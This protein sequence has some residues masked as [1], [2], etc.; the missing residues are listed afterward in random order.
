MMKLSDSSK[1][2]LILLGFSLVIFNSVSPLKANSTGLVPLTELGSDMY[3]GYEGGLYP[4]G[5][6][7]IPV[8]HLALG[9]M[10]A[11]EVIPRDANGNPDPNG[12]IVMI[13][14]GMSNTCHEFG[15]FERVADTDTYRN[16]RLVIINGAQGGQAAE[17][18]DD[19]NAP[20]W[21]LITERLAGNNLTVQQVQVAW[22][23]QANR[24]PDNNFP[25]HA[26]G[27][28][29]N[30]R[31]IVSIMHNRYSNLKLFYI[32][33]R[34]YA[35]YATGNLNP[36]PQSYESGF[37]VKWLIGDQINGDADLNNDPDQSPVMAPWLGWGPYLWADGLIPRADGLIWER[38]DFEGD[39]THPSAG[40]EQK[41]ADL[42][43]G[44]FGTVATTQWYKARAGT[45]LVH[46]DTEADAH[47][48]IAEPGV[49]FG[50][51][52]R[53]QITGGETKIYLRFDLSG[54]RVPVIRSKLSM[55]T[56]QG[57][58][59]AQL[60]TVEDSSWQEGTITF[61]NAPTPANDSFITMGN[62]SRDGSVSGDVTEQVNADADGIV[63]FAVVAGGG[64]G[65]CHS[66]EGGQPPRL[67][68]TLAT[69]GGDITGN[70]IT[71]FE[72]LG[73]L[74]GHWLW[75]GAA[76]GVG[77][78]VIQD[79]IVNF[80]DYSKLTGNWMKIN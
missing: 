14:I 44:F 21:R 63:T 54:I 67:I 22:M 68:L 25:I 11:D 48:W 26:Q 33:S 30:L 20:Y 13:S 70:G 35:G 76:G 52:S 61:Y 5:S 65:S 23:K 47:V 7:D 73:R 15:V 9:Q 75:I 1:T 72:D 60:F 2:N 69:S 34:T 71:D 78:D 32:S 77:G 62:V 46:L 55:R 41:V 4:G 45:A 16:G 28:A 64:N 58:P 3:M 66:R 17:D 24:R 27:L 42:L 31:S 38:Q 57:A 43:S 40:G 10:R 74:V 39:G 51:A 37:S 59:S 80:A 50:S 53:L 29:A 18:I 56:A 79:G 8:A 19:Y 12:W 36:E 49:N 6:N